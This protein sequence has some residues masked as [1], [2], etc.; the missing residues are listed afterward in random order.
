[1]LQSY[2]CLQTTNRVVYGQFRSQ[3]DDR[4]SDEIDDCVVDFMEAIE[5]LELD[6]GKNLL[7]KFFASIPHT[8]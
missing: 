3:L 1:M 5:N 4:I 2:T 6:H 8:L 7:D